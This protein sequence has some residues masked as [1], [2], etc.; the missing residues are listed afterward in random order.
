MQILWIS[1]FDIGS[2]ELV[3]PVP[4]QPRQTLVSNRRTLRTPPVSANQA[5]MNRSFSFDPAVWSHHSSAVFGRSCC[6]REPPRFRGF[7]RA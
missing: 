4:A 5:R 7:S 1:S 3:R 6:P 2:I